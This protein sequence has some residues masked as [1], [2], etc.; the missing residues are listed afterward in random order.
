[1]NASND[2][3]YVIDGIPMSVGSMAD[4]NPNDIESMEI[5]KDASA[6]AIYGSRGANGVILITTKKGKTG[7]V[8]INYDG[9]V[10]FSKIHSMTDWMNSGELI[11]WNRQA[12]VNAGAYTGKYGNAPDPDIDGDAYFGVFLSI[13]IYVL[14]LMLLFNLMLMELLYYVMQHNMKKKY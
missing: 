14:F 6:T 12:N 3:L 2:P 8:T 4:V 9:T 11:D 7:K 5:L 10:S 1:M 13:L